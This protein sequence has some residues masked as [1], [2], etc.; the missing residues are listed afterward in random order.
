MA[1]IVGTAAMLAE[2][3]AVGA[4]LEP[5]SIPAPD[6]VPFGDWLTCFPGFAMLTADRPGQGRM[7]SPIARTA[8][9]GTATAEPGVR[10]LWPDGVE[11][12]AVCPTATGLLPG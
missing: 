10:L 1:G 7:T 4:T 11:T 6:G 3:S 5:D 8:R 12:D 9:I 2:A